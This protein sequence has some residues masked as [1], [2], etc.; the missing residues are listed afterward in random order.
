MV[1]NKMAAVEQ[2]AMHFSMDGNQIHQESDEARRQK[3]RKNIHKRKTAHAGTD[4]PATTETGTDPEPEGEAGEGEAGEADAEAEEGDGEEAAEATEEPEEPEEGGEKK[5][6]RNQFNF[7]ERASQTFNYTTKER[8][9]MTVPPPR[10]SFSGS[11][12]QWEIYDA[13][14]ADKAAKAAKTEKKKAPSDTSAAAP[15]FDRGAVVGSDET[16]SKWF[17]A[18]KVVTLEGSKK[19]ERMVVQN[20]FDD[21]LQDFKFWDDDSDEFKTEG[22]LL[23]LW[24]FAT[25]NCRKKTIT[26]MMFNPK[27]SDLV[28]V[29]FGSY[30]YTVQDAGAFACY[31]LKNAASPEYFIDTDSGVMSID[32]LSTSVNLVA[33]GMYDGSVAVYDLASDDKS[34][35]TH[36]STAVTGKHTDP[37]WQVAWQT[38]DLEKRHNFYSVSADGYVRA[39][40]M[41]KNELHYRNVIQLR[42]PDEPAGLN[43][44]LY[45]GTCFAFNPE[46]EHLFLVGTEGGAVLKCSKAYSSQYLSTYD[47]H[48][49]AVY[50]IAWNKFHPRVFA[51]CGADWSLKI[52]DHSYPISL[53]DFDLGS[54]VGA[55]A[56]APYSASVFAAVTA[57]GKVHIFDLGVSKTDP[58]CVQPVVRKGKLTHIC[59]NADYP[60][61]VVG[62]DH[63]CVSSLKLSPN[64]RKAMG[65]KQTK[66]DEIARIEKLLD[67]VKELDIQTG[68]PLAQEE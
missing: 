60:I 56:W 46:A 43:P 39:W 26:A 11:C 24:K 33:V 18:A 1:F 41:V 9:M 51:T 5:L 29:G 55:V 28:A 67:S 65:G 12:T 64:L 19:I 6:L 40:T 3:A 66:E 54:P 59:F 13:Y 36:K 20:I 31:S 30:D 8:G 15:T 62:D 22:S 16:Q 63:G 42:R 21:V 32:I 34:V 37:V 48:S 7:S 44:L 2:C 57:D 53:F 10:S 27:Y 14:K 4:A 68:K 17:Q 35:P 61:I 52:W 50:S 38:D 23:P 25:E 58:I 45:A 47:A 49:M